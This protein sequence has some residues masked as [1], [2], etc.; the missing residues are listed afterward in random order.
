MSVRVRK[1]Q[2][3]EFGYSVHKVYTYDKWKESP[4]HSTMCLR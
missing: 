4:D 1:T 3:D 2:E